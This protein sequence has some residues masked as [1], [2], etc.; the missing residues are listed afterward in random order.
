MGITF[1]YS[2]RRTSKIS[3][4]LHRD[5]QSEGLPAGLSEVSWLR[6][7]FLLQAVEALQPGEQ[8]EFWNVIFSQFLP[9]FFSVFSNFMFVRVPTVD[10]WSN[11]VSDY[12]RCGFIRD[13]KNQMHKNRAN[14]TETLNLPKASSFH[15]RS[16]LSIA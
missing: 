1:P 9:P 3:A 13:T 15:F 11:Q 2:L 4:S 7:L 8:A 12:L 14:Q 10:G 6:L 5:F 16:F